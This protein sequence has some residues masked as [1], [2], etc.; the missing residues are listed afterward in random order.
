MY[1]KAAQLKLRFNTSR[2][3]IGVEN[4]WDLPLTELAKHVRA[5]KSS[6][7]KDDDDALNFLDETKVVDTENELRFDILKD[8]YMTKKAQKESIRDEAQIKE[9]NQKILALIESKKEDSLKNMSVEDLEKLL[10]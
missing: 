1:K 8:V 5:L 3:V 2:G 4:L 7:K 9:H 10:K 6:L